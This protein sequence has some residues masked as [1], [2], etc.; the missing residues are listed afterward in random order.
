MTQQLNQEKRLENVYLKA[1]KYGIVGLMTL[2]LLAIIV[3]VSMAGYQYAQ[4]PLPPAPA[5]EPPQTVIS[6]EDLKNALLEEE[7]RR[8][9]LEKNGGAP[10][11]QA[12][13]PAQRT[14]R[15]AEDV[16]SLY[17]CAEE[18][19]RLAQQPIE[20]AAEAVHAQRREDLRQ[21]IERMARGEFRSDPWVKAM[22]AFA[23]TVLRDPVIAK[24]KRDAAIGSV[25]GPTIQ[26]HGNVWTKIERDK[27][28]FRR[29][30]ADRVRGEIAT[31]AARIAAA[32]AKA[33]LMLTAA[34]AL[35]ALLFM[36][37]LY[38]IFAKM[39]DNLRLI[40]YDLGRP[41]QPA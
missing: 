13:A 25:V 32:K 28:A 30:E 2:A 41:P 34:G 3:L 36:L 8:K 24:L 18:F 17:R 22:T 11:D 15:Y 38:L 20:A 6:L 10:K 29:A 7:K 5:K 37:A 39:E 40:H 9:E 4:T 33:V 27:D 35:I 16:L 26:F 12:P 19:A 23:C 14:Q 21:S 1:F 31:E